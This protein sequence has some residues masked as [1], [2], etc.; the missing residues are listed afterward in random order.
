MKSVLQHASIFLFLVST[1]QGKC[2]VLMMKQSKLRTCQKEADLS[3]CFK[4]ILR[5]PVCQK[6]LSKAHDFFCNCMEKVATNVCWMVKYLKFFFFFSGIIPN[7][8]QLK[9][10]FMNKQMMESIWLSRAVQYG[11]TPKYSSFE[12]RELYWSCL[13]ANLVCDQCFLR[14]ECDWQLSLCSLSQQFLVW[15]V[16]GDVM[17]RTSCHLSMK[18]IPV[19]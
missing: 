17:I 14:L 11:P 6:K 16:P 19:P 15:Y 18:E 10:S 5:G 9:I 8:N 7:L 13:L 2:S 12:E 1:F 4:V 3:Q